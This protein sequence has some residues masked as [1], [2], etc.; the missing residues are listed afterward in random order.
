MKYILFADSVND[1]VGI[2]GCVDDWEPEK[3]FVVAVMSLGYTMLI[4][5][6]LNEDVITESILAVGDKLF[7]QAN[8]MSKE[9]EKQLVYDTSVDEIEQPW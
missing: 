2:T 8:R 1:V 6:S 3:E 9:I 5:D 7:A 4:A